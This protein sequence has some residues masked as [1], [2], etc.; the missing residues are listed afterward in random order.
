MAICIGKLLRPGTVVFVDAIPGKDWSD[1]SENYKNRLSAI[2]GNFDNSWVSMPFSGLYLQLYINLYRYRLNVYDLN[3][4]L[5]YIKIKISNNKNVVMGCDVVWSRDDGSA[6]KKYKKYDA[7]K[8]ESKFDKLDIVIKQ[9]Q[10]F[11]M[12]PVVVLT[13]LNKKLISTYSPEISDEIIN[14]FERYNDALRS[15]LAKNNIKYFELTDI[16]PSECFA[17]I[18]HTNSLGNEIV[19]ERIAR[20]IKIDVR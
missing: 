20:F 13:P 3:N 6:L 17:D 18:F 12:K 15:H 14:C 11:S 8:I 7:I 19:A 16:V 4:I 10:K 5:N 2:L 1:E 9:L